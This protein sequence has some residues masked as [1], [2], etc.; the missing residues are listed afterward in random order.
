MEDTYTITFG[1]RGA[2]GADDPEVLA[3]FQIPTDFDP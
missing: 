1:V 2:G 3:W